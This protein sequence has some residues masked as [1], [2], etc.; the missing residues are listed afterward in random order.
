M[1]QRLI[2]SLA[3]CLLV[4]LGARADIVVEAS[5]DSTTILI[6][7]QVGL[8]AKVTAPKGT[9]IIFPEYP[10][11]Y[12]T[13]GVEVLERSKVDTS[14]IDDGHRWVLRRD[15]LLTS[16]DSAL[17]RL[18]AVEVTSGSKTF[19]S[20]G[21][22]GLKVNSV[23]VDTLH[24][25]DLRAPY[26]PVDIPFQ[27]DG[28]FVATTL[29]LWVLLAAFAFSLCR[30]LK[31]EPLK[32][33]ITVAPPPP[34]HQVALNAIAKFKGRTADTEEDLK[35]YY[36]ELT[37]VLRTYIK[38]RFGIDAL[39][40]TTMQIVDAITQTGDQTALYELRELLETADLVK[41]ARMEASEVDNDRSL[42]HAMEYVK[43]TK[44]TE[45]PPQRIVKVVDVDLRRR[46][47]RIVLRWLL[48]LITGMATLSMAIYIVYVLISN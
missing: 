19:R 23:A 34:A 16:F 29:L 40:M 21:S 4:A 25:D 8:H 46:R 38:E 10:D 35:H 33:R 12:L 27:W 20:S 15:Y 28:G 7:E 45:A 26:G 44:P 5:L 22:L 31:R 1:K 6:G 24:P 17:Y 3:C 18:P 9:R 14:V 42:L 11:G 36:D 13:E 37:E 30:L 32:R 2:L 48:T 39:E 47:T 41:F 43:Q